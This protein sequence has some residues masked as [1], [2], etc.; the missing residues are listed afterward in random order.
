MAETP[1]SFEQELVIKLTEVVQRQHSIAERLLDV[2]RN[3]Q[4]AQRS[5]DHYEKTVSS[6]T[7][8]KQQLWKASNTVGH[9]INRIFKVG[10]IAAGAAVGALA[11]SIKTS[12]GAFYELELASSEA[13]HALERL[14]SSYNGLIKNSAATLVSLQDVS[15]ALTD[16]STTVSRKALVANDDFQRGYISI[17]DTLSR[18]IGNDDA[19][20]LINSL[21]DATDDYRA[22]TKDTI[23]QL[24]GLGKAINE[25]YTTGTGESIKNAQE[26]IYKA[27]AAL[28]KLA[29]LA[30]EEGFRLLQKLQE[31]AV[32]LQ[33]SARGAIPIKSWTDATSRLGV[34]FDKIQ[35]SILESFGPAAGIF[36]Q[37]LSRTI[38][39]TIVPAIE[40]AS[41]AF[42]AWGGS[43]K[44][45]VKLKDAFDKAGNALVTVK[46]ALMIA[47]EWAKKFGEAIAYVYDRF[48]NLTIAAA[49]FVA[50]VG[51]FKSISL[52]LQGLWLPVKALGEHFLSASK[53][54]GALSTAVKGV[55]GIGGALAGGAGGIAGHIG[56]RMVGRSIGGELG[57]AEG[58]GGVLGAAGLGTAMG[59]PVIGAIMGVTSAIE[60]MGESIV[61]TLNEAKKANDAIEQTQAAAQSYSSKVKANAESMITPYQQARQKVRELEAE[62]MELEANPPRGLWDAI[63]G[64]TS[65]F[66]ERVNTL[67]ANILQ[68]HQSAQ[69]NKVQSPSIDPDLQE[70]INQL[71]ERR[72]ELIIQA[73]NASQA[74][75][76]QMV[77][78]ITNL[79]TEI[80]KQ[81][82][83][84]RLL[85]EQ[86]KNEILIAQIQKSAG[87]IDD[88]KVKE[89]ALRQIQQLEARNAEL[90]K[91]TAATQS[92]SAA[93]IIEKLEKQK[94]L[95]A[96]QMKNVQPDDSKNVEELRRQSEKLNEAI[97]EAENR[98]KNSSAATEDQK[99]QFSSMKNEAK[100]VIDRIKDMSVAIAEIAEPAAII[101]NAGK[102]MK[103]LGEAMMA[104]GPQAVTSG[105][106]MSD[107]LGRQV[108]DA[109]QT[110]TDALVKSQAAFAAAMATDDPA[111]RAKRLAEASESQAA[112]IQAQQTASQELV[113]TQEVYLDRISK[114]R[115]IR[116]AELEM[117][118]AI[119][120]TASLAV[121]AQL[122]LVALMTKEKEQLQ[123]QK[124]L[125]DNRLATIS[126]EIT[127]LETIGGQE[128]RI[129]ALR[130]QAWMWQNKSL[131]TSGKIRK[132]QAQQLQQIKEL[133]D[134]YLDAVQAQAFGAG[135]F[136]KILIT[137]DQNLL[138]GLEKRISKENFLLGQI[139]EAAG[140]SDV[141]AR[142]F[143][144]GGMG[145]M[146]DT[147]TGKPVSPQDVVTNNQEFIKNIGDQASRQLAEESQRIFLGVENSINTQIGSM[148]GLT[149]SVNKLND[150]FNQIIDNKFGATGGVAPLAG[151]GPASTT[152]FGQ[153]AEDAVRGQNRT[154]STLFEGILKSVSNASQHAPAVNDIGGALN[155]V[156]YSK[157]GPSKVLAK[158][159]ETL[160]SIANK[161]LE[162]RG[163]G[164]TVKTDLHGYDMRSAHEI[165]EENKQRQREISR[166]QFHR[167]R[168]QPS[169]TSPEGA[170]D[171]PTPQTM[172]SR[173]AA[174]GAGSL[175][176]ATAESRTQGQLKG[177]THG[178]KGGNTWES[179]LKM[180]SEVLRSLGPFIDELASKDSDVP[181]MRQTRSSGRT[182]LGPP[183]T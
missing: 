55:G 141:R 109:I 124:T 91:S 85:S 15:R 9:S 24:A 1:L 78:Q 89:D 59:G 164:G 90:A 16:Y 168:A 171:Q 63:S 97:E 118:K 101:G 114:V 150:T 147:Q 34:L 99:N 29:S 177:L 19:V 57:A 166:L 74:D 28:E 3:A 65:A 154:A 53:N 5:L 8:A 20:K 83:I 155:A 17:L 142:K 54:A 79:Q 38:S 143:S 130:S 43:E 73:T 123:E 87:A 96:E 129:N 110:S 176:A 103:N 127:Q 49:G 136:E 82:E 94:A 161:L 60:T 139:G 181:V 27:V 98:F 42:E 137:Q 23:P 50:L 173:I 169:I 77:G 46:S 158:A 40:R 151:G 35:Q 148:D 165:A 182:A 112:A 75:R 6:L 26:E 135:K 44:L 107:T 132:V 133:R 31:E 2:N 41:K 140:R 68:A 61:A 116:E 100:S 10:V 64:E 121:Q 104:L 51:P 120:G 12:G 45:I 67:R 81:T 157:V 14:S 180:V 13:G 160:E 152:A 95:L 39:E 134:G 144:A 153:A 7:K 111:V 115:E 70:K 33:K 48:P 117:S 21:L 167:D 93:E 56:G 62:L 174:Q 156:D 36:I 84:G 47:W 52:V 113:R 69:A 145:Q 183:G 172:Q 86:R 102:A 66:Q 170:I 149:T 138:K 58:V 119:Y 25:A 126:A 175:D 92:G 162:A 88:L 128:D 108:Q 32:N 18:G 71:E 159:A 131:E 76:Q 122:D 30:P 125:Y 37:Q 106:L 178:K 22:I 80:D 163:G 11:K 72:K 4:K 105:Q 146:I 179:K